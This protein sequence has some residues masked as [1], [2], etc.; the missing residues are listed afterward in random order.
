MVMTRRSKASE[1]KAKCLGLLDEVAQTGETLVITKRGKPIARLSSAT[2]PRRPIF[3]ALKGWIEGDI[4]GPAEVEWEAL[5]DDGP[6]RQ[7]GPDL[8]RGGQSRS[9]KTRPP[10][11]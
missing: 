6:A 9:R 3:G 10:R 4:E 5:Q 2:K 7:P 11:R 1:F 8:A